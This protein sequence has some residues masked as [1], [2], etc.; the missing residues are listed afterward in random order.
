M[1]KAWLLNPD[2]NEL[3]VEEK[4]RSWVEELRTD[5]YVT[6]LWQFHM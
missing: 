2:L 4:F 5:K 3:Y 1:L 6:V